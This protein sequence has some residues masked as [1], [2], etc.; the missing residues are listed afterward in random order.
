MMNARF[1]LLTKTFHF[2]QVLNYPASSSSSVI[3]KT[4]SL[5]QQHQH[6][7]MTSSS[8]TA[9]LIEKGKKASAYMAIDENV[10]SVSGACKQ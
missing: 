2:K 10:N 8:S 9:N 6:I 7:Q 3:I 5:Q 1:L 4:N